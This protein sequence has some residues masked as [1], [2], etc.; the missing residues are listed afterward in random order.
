MGR[1]CY[2]T[3]HLGTI[4]IPAG[5]RARKLSRRAPAKRSEVGGARRVRCSFCHPGTSFMEHYACRGTKLIDVTELSKC[6]KC[7]KKVLAQCR[8]TSCLGASKLSRYRL[9]FTNLCAC[10]GAQTI[11]KLSGEQEQ[12]K[13]CDEQLT[14]IVRVLGSCY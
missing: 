2:P 12:S 10:P 5:R 6:N 11:T 1:L 3:L 8:G 14:H 13:N 9:Y 7:Y 4:L